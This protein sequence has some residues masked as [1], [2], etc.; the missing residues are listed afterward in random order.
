MVGYGE[1]VAA[2][3]NDVAID[4]QGPFISAME[5]DNTIANI[6]PVMKSAYDVTI[7]D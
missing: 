7:Y 1:D 5:T 3:V 6:R 2:F 4:I